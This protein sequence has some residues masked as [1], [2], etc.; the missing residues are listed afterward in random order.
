M[1]GLIASAFATMQKELEPFLLK[2]HE[3][4]AASIQHLDQHLFVDSPVW[5]LGCTQYYLGRV[6][7]LQRVVSHVN[8]STQHT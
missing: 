8:S 3:N 5:P 4:D 7:N 2:L 1:E 6:P